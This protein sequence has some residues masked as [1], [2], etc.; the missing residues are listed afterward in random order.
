[1]SQAT[2]H[3]LFD[4]ILGLPDEERQLLEELIAEEEEK[5]WRREIEPARQRFAE[6]GLGLDDIDRAV[7]AVRRAG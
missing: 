7:A 1:M 6:Q 2:V 3:E 5:E 4:R